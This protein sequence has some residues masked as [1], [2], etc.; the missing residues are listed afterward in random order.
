[1]GLFLTGRVRLE[2]TDKTRIFRILDNELYQDDDDY[3]Y[4]VPRYMQTDNYTIPLWI[5]AIGGSPVD[6]RVEPSHLHD[7]ACY[8]FAVV[9][10][11]LTKEELQEKGF[12]RYSNN[13]GMWVCEN[14]PR[15]FLAVRPITKM[16]ANNLLY[17]AM[18]AAGVPF[19]KRWIVRLGTI[20]NIGWFIKQCKKAN[21]S[22]DFD[23]LYNKDFWDFVGRK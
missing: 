15:E 10:V 5:S 3:I 1:M 19:I 2:Q 23:K 14:I 21:I 22:I 7:F 20:F 13:R 17:R 11:T 18:R 8:A 6:Y 16:Q 9:Y 12:Y 4:L